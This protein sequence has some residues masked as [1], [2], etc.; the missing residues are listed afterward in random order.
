[1]FMRTPAESQAR[2]AVLW[3]DGRRIQLRGGMLKS[4]RDST[5]TGAL[6]MP[7]PRLV[8]GGRY[9]RNVLNGLGE[10]KTQ[11]PSTLQFP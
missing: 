11:G 3:G 10:G 6:R 2:Q 7:P 8:G 4:N 9:T 1:M 5:S